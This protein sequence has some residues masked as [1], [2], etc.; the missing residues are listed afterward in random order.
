MR[1]T[2]TIHVDE[3]PVEVELRSARKSDGLRRAERMMDAAKMDGN[4]GLKQ[5]AFFLYPTCIAAT[6]T[7]EIAKM[8]L[9]DFVEKVD[10]ADV[11]KW[12][13]TAYELNPQWRDAFKVMA[14]M[15]AE[16]EKKISTP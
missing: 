3:Q 12:A 11:D 7:E 15:G 5:V 6:V 4:D 1:K 10:E 13:E 14:E 8:T 2:I 9:T 16:A